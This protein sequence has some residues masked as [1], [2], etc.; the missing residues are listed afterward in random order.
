[1]LNITEI[2]SY[3]TKI[4]ENHNFRKIVESSMKIIVGISGASG[5]IYSVR[6]LEVLRELNITTYSII[7]NVAEKIINLE[8]DKSLKYVKSLAS[9][10]YRNSD[11]L[12]PISSGSFQIDGMVIVPCSMKTL[13]GIANGYSE[14]LLLRAADVIL[15]QRKPL[16]LIPREMPLNLIHLENMTKLATAGA[17]IMPANPAFYHKP[18]NI[19]DLVN[20]VVGKILD[21]LG[22]KHNIYLRWRG[23]L[24]NKIT[25]D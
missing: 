25:S 14:N 4:D 13:G 9:R 15:K 3:Y 19:D 8:L 20:Y 24:H 12:A 6:L 17:I 21:L 1:M 23:R 2:K 7:T 10:W 5:V 11:I 22:V 16:I 18:T